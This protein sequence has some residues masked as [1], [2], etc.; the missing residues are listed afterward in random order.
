[1]PPSVPWGIAAYG[2]SVYVA[3]EQNGVLNFYSTDGTEYGEAFGI[4]PT[5]LGVVSENLYYTQRNAH[6]VQFLDGLLPPGAFP[7]L[8]SPFG[9]VQD[10]ADGYVYV[11]DYAVTGTT[12]AVRRY[13]QEGNEVPLPAGAF[14]GPYNPLGIAISY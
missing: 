4:E 14:V 7:N 11:V 5:G 8:T 13:D 12:S 2:G 3:D 6:D 10:P 9:I 1:M